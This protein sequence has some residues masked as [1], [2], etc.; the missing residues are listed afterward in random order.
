MEKIKVGGVDLEYSTAG[1]GEPVLFVPPGPIA[2]SFLP[3]LSDRSLT[4][5]YRLITYRQRGQGGSSL[6]TGITTFEQHAAD[7]ADLLRSLGIR[8]AHV[9]GHSTGAEIAMQLAFD[10]PSLVHT[11]VLLEPPLTSVPSAAAF[12]AGLEPILAMYRAGDRT[13]AMSAFLSAVS[14]LDWPACRDVIDTYEPGATL[15]AIADADTFFSNILVA[16][17]E[18]K[19]G[20][21]EAAVIKQ[22]VIAFVGTESA[23]FFWECEAL[24]RRWFPHLTERTLDG[25]GHLLHIQR[26]GPFA[27]MLAAHLA[28]HP[29]YGDRS[30]GPE[31]AGARSG[32]YHRSSR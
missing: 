21:R 25:A 16:L 24:L 4:D 12:F 8:R 5:R 28:Q 31:S 14:G 3:L 10:E 17:G 1:S 13:G 23:P 22:P 11:L 9:V 6:T 29:I 27:S 30:T 15:Q 20:A 19:F 7:A 26:P 32:N 2:D 18:W